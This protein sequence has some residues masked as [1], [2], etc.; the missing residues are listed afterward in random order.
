M[1]FNLLSRLNNIE[2]D[3][4]TLTVSQI[5]GLPEALALKADIELVNARV[6]G[7]IDGAGPAMN[8][9][10]GDDSSMANRLRG[11]PMVSTAPVRSCSCMK[12]EPPRLFASLFT[13]IQ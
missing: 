10:N 1:A 3:V 2:S 4:S 13:P 12:R 9:L 5:N 7:L 8:T 11:A 6:A